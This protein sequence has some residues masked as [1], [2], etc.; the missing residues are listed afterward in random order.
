METQENTLYRVVIESLLGG[1]LVVPNQSDEDIL[2]MEDDG[3]IIL[4]IEKQSHAEPM[5]G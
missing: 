4:N 3:E 1:S 2:R 5:W